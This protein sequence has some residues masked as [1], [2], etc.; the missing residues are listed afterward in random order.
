M[1]ANA[2]QQEVDFS[3]PVCCDIF[4]DPVVLLCGHSFCKVCLQEWWR[5]SRLQTCPLCKEIF[6]MSQP[7]RNLVLR[8]V[9]DT[10]RHERS[11]RSAKG[12][13]E[14]CGQHG[15]K[16]KLF[17]RDDRQ[18]V[19]LICRDEK[20]HQKHNCVPIDEAAAEY[21][22]K[23]KVQLMYLK[24]EL[25]SFERQKLTCDKMADHIKFQ[26]QQTEK[27]MKEEFQ[28]LYQLVRA[29]EA[30]RIDAVRKEA[31]LKS[32]AMNLRIV[33][34]SAEIY[35][36]TDKIRTIERV[37]KAGDISIMQNFKTTVQ[38][39]ACEL[40]KPETPTG[41]LL[42]EAKHLGNLQFS[43]WKKMKDTIRYTP[44]TLDPNTGSQG[45]NLSQ[46]LN[47]LTESSKLQP[48]PSNPERLRGLNILGYEGFNSGKH[49]WDVEVDGYWNL[50]VA[51][52]TKDP[53]LPKR[54]GIYMCV[55]TDIV[56]EITPEDYVKEVCKDEF[57]QT[58]R[59]Q[60]DYNQGILSF[61]DL[62]RKTPVHTMK[63]TFTETVFPYFYSRAK[64]LP[65]EL[66][67]S[68]REPRYQFCKTAKAKFTR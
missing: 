33:N 53:S 31:A 19:C 66:S 9:A 30:A 7:P 5:Q 63:Y 41:A 11:R 61:F 29:E 35:S 42:D 2:S 52:K 58:I 15:V 59:V 51:A 26:V 54:W 4:T 49:S 46:H 45:L 27:R 8:N 16:L 24:T 67:L 13:E 32:E 37:M 65:A 14:L 47:H 3:C 60:L 18:L 50:G 36:L 38:R 56:R 62:V 40:P 57:P 48:L 22:T 44:V 43:V 10:M 25:G 1:A 28:K 34:W 23:L 68:V 55:C 20:K 64:I 21:R 6:P 39:S 17:C 12:S